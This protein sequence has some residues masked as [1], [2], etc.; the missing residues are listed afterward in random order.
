MLTMRN[1]TA[2]CQAVNTL[3]D[4]QYRARTISTSVLCREQDGLFDAYLLSKGR[5]QCCICSAG[6]LATPISSALSAT[7]SKNTRYQ[8]VTSGDLSR[9]IREATGRNVDRFF[10]D[11]IFSPGNP[12]SSTS[13]WNYDTATQMLTVTVKQTQDTSNR[14]ATFTTC[15]LDIAVLKR[16][17]SG[18]VQREV[19]KMR[20]DKT[21]NVLYKF[22][23]ASKPDAVLIDPGKQHCRQTHHRSGRR[24]NCPAIVLGGLNIVD[25][26]Y[27]A[28]RIAEKGMND[29]TIALFVQALKTEGDQR[30]SEALIGYLAK[31]EKETLRPLYRDEIKK[32]KSAPPCCRDRQP[33]DSCRAPT[34]TLQT[35]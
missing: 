2:Q 5:C 31:T 28:G 12:G 8:N 20:T 10:D 30:G 19:Y 14:H 9:A 23:L 16:G 25:R 27:A 24:V 6:N 32:Q 7:I 33:S 3:S 26:K 34:K 22:H 4:E 29:E 11:W 35:A 17:D 15:P 13:A 1:A 18:S 21:E